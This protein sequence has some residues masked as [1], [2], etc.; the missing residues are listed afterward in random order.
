RPDRRYRADAP[1][2]ARD[3]RRD[4]LPQSRR[5]AGAQ[6]RQHHQRVPRRLHLRAAQGPHHGGR[7][8]RRRR[9]RAREHEGHAARIAGGMGGVRGCARG[10][11]LTTIHLVV[12]GPLDQ[13]TGGYRYS[14]H[15][16]ACWRASGTDVV[17]HE[18]PGRFPEPDARARDAAATLLAKLRDESRVVIDGLALPAFY[19]RLADTRVVALIHH[20]LGLETGLAQAAARRWLAAEAAAL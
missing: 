8:G 14:K 15:M 1:G 10:R 3:A 5:R 19:E 17:V 16:V 13:A 20:P 12:P 7:A 2:A 9:G 6:G 18:L 11:S 4:R